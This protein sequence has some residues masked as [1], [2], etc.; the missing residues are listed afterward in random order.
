MQNQPNNLPWTEADEAFVKYISTIIEQ[1]LIRARTMP[2]DEWQLVS[3]DR[4]SAELASVI[5]FASENQRKGA[6]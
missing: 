1:S 2:E 4:R 5:F 6:P 3:V